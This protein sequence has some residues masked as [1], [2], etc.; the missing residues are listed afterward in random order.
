MPEPMLLVLASLGLPVV[1]AA[2]VGSVLLVQWLLDPGRPV[3]PVWE[4]PELA[5]LEAGPARGRH[6]LLL[7]DRAAELIAR[8]RGHQPRHDLD[9]TPPCI[10][11]TLALL[12]PVQRARELVRQ[13]G[14]AAW[15]PPGQRPRWARRVQLELVRR[16][17]AAGEPAAWFGPPAGVLP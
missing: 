17:R 15:R 13:L 11:A 8:D 2:V 14:Q 3:T 10:A 16:L 1:A 6:R 7:S 5:R 9:G 4:A 12:S